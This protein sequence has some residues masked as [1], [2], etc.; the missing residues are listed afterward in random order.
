MPNLQQAPVLKT[1]GEKE[2]DKTY[3]EIPQKLADIVFNELGNASAQLR[4]M[5]VLIGTKPGFS[6]SEKWILERTGLQHASYLTARKALE[7]KGW[8]TCDAAKSITI[9]YDVIYGRGNMVLPQPSNMVLPQRGNMVLPIINKET[10][11]ITNKSATGG[12]A[13]SK[14]EFD[15][16]WGF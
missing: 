13:S 3:Y 10:N 8:L 14:E 15:A 2:K 6:V 16:Q 5:L 1:I 12:R 9:N 4:V 11:K 7:K